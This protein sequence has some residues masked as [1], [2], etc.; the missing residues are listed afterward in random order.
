MMSLLK[1]LPNRD[2]IIQLGF[3]IHSCFPFLDVQGNSKQFIFCP[4]T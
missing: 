1:G 4:T 2:K 3:G